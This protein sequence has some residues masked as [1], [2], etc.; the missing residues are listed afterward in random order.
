MKTCRFSPQ[1][2]LESGFDVEVRTPNM[3]WG[4]MTSFQKACPIVIRRQNKIPEVL[5]FRHPTAGRQFIKGTV[6]AG[7]SPVEAAKRE[8]REESGIHAH[9]PFI[10]LGTQRIGKDRRLWHFFQYPSIGLPET[11]THQTKDDFGHR[12]E[13]FWHPLSQPLDQ[14]WHPDFHEA[15]GFFA[16]RCRPK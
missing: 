4:W 10:S 9:V 7:E 2:G 1:D 14:R 6:E 3:R 16:P 13:F 15:F 12:F 11:W 8:L 5:A